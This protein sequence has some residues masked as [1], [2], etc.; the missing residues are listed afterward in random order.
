MTLAAST[1]SPA[2][3]TNFYQ[4][5][6]TVLTEPVVHHTPQGRIFTH[7]SLQLPDPVQQAA[8]YHPVIWSC[9]AWG[10]LAVWV[11][12]HVHAGQ[13]VAVHGFF[14]RRQVPGRAAVTT[15]QCR[16]VTVLTAADAPP[17]V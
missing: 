12:H 5:K 6:G 8:D 15:L 2:P 3:L 14:R 13:H 9:T 7:F 17:S 16:H 4:A 1:P 11:T 10:S